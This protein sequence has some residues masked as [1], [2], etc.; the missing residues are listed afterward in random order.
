MKLSLRSV[1]P[2]SLLLLTACPQVAPHEDDELCE[3]LVEGPAVA[4]TA[5][6]EGEG[7]LVATDHQ[8]YDI[9]LP[10]RSDGSGNFGIVR[11]VSGEA[12][13]YRIA[14]DADVPLTIR[15]GN[16]N[17]VAFEHSATASEAC[18]EIKALHELAL[19]VGTYSFSFGPTAQATVRAVIEASAHD[20][21]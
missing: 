13:H 11:L 20:E 7:P 15:D 10:A 14:L 8:R 12:T 21:H 6:A 17:T 2:M 19:G 5:V 9:T 18:T 16:G 4:V 3:H 1:L